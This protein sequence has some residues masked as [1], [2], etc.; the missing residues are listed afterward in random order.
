MK[1]KLHLDTLKLNKYLLPGVTVKISLKKNDPKHCLFYN[2][3][4]ELCKINF[5]SIFLKARRIT[6]S[7][8]EMYNHQLLLQKQPAI[9]P[10][11]KNIVKTLNVAFSSA[12]VNVQLHDGDLPNRVVLALVKTDTKAGDIKNNPFYFEHFKM[13]KID[14]KV[15]SKNVVFTDGLSMK[16]SSQDNILE[17]YNTLYSCISPCSKDIS[18]YEYTR[19]YFFIA[20][21]LTPDLCSGEHFNNLRDGRLEVSMKFE[22]SQAT[23]ISLIAYLEF[24]NV[25]SVSETKKV[26]CSYQ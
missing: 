2:K 18:I 25:I 6:V 8:S 9:Y 24:D 5:Q 20:Y 1:G 12:L 13:E 11:K 23:S 4:A 21:D 19:G 26:T 14:L 10:Y 17:A 7:P 15:S 22:V 3:T 16:T